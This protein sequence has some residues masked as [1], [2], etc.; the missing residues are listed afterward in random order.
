MVDG[1]SLFRVRGVSVYPAE[2][3]AAAIADRIKAL[4]ADRKVPVE[5]LVVRETPHASV[6]AAGDRQLLTIVD[7]DA[8]L[9]GV[10]RP[11]RRTSIIDGWRKQSSG[12][13]RIGNRRC[14]GA[15]GLRPPLRAW[16]S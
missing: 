7:E 11:I 4:A 15:M 13:G 10:S 8:E 2:T 12:S 9:E 5:S 1:V 6:L 16:S 3:R 14:S